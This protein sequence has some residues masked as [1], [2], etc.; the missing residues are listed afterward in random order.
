MRMSSTWLF[1]TLCLGACTQHTDPVSSSGNV[2]NLSSSPS[3][4]NAGT[5][6][7]AASDALAN[8]STPTEPSAPI[9]P[10]VLASLQRTACY[11]WCP[12][13]ELTVYEDG[14][15]EYEGR[16]YVKTKGKVSS[17][18]DP[19]KLQALREAYRAAQFFSL[20]NYPYVSKTDPTDGPSAVLYYAEGGHAKVVEHYRGSKLAPTSL[21]TLESSFDSLLD[22][23]QWI[24]TE[25]ERSILNRG[26]R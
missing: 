8:Q 17:K 11:G 5:S 26:G 14:R 10:G 4:A 2:G 15:V 18:L 20:G 16:E 25:Q 9:R 21:A 22:V 12:T 13:Y 7:P 1:L 19:A 3:S 24:G 6:P 23:Q